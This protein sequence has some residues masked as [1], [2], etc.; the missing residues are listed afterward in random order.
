M[1]VTELQLPLMPFWFVKAR[2][3]SAVAK[4]AEIVT[5]ALARFALSASL[6]V[7][8]VS[9]AVAAAFSV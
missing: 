8:P 1:P 7:S 6:T 9:I 3:S 4:P 2:V 5:V